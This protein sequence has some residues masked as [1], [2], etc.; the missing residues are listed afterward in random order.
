MCDT[1]AHAHKTLQ[2]TATHCNA[3]QHTTTPHML[4]VRHTRTRTHTN[5]HAHTSRYPPICPLTLQKLHMGLYQQDSA[6]IF[7]AFLTYWGL[8]HIFRALFTYLGLFSY[9]RGSF[10]IVLFKCQGELSNSNLKSF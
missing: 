7:R 1:H 5:I 2:N 6:H 10:H 9:I 3:L 4:H 8:L